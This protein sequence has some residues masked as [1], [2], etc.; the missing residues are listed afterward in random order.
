MIKKTSKERRKTRIRGK[1]KTSGKGRKLTVFRSN[2]YL[3][4][5]IID[6]PSGKTLVGANGKNLLKSRPKLVNKT[7]TERAF[8][9]GKEIA[10]KAQKKEIKRVVFDRGSY[11]YHGRVKALAEGARAGGLRL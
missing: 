1:I 8:E 7:K 6:V 4:A 10:K 5:Q 3:W 2:Q 11:R 9:L